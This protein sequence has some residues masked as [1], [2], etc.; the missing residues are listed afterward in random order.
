MTNEE[1]ATAIKN[2]DLDEIPFL[3]N[4]TFK[5]IYLL[6]KRFYTLNE[7][8]CHQYMVGLED[9]QQAGYFAFLTAID[10]FE[11]AR[12]YVFVSYL[13]YSTLNEF[14]AMIG[15]R[16][17]KGYKDPLATAVSLDKPLADADDMVV[18]DTVPDR[19]GE[20]AYESVLDDADRESKRN[21]LY[22]AIDHLASDLKP[23]VI[24]V[25]FKNRKLKDIAL[26]FNI[27]FTRAGTLKAKAL[28][29]L[30]IAKELQKYKEE[31]IITSAY[32]GTG[33]NSF[34]SLWASSV[35]QTVVGL[36]RRGLLW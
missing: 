16:T 23:I 30:R 10:S 34:K 9:L 19:S 27:D 17:K 31:Y 7:K 6:A 14:N 25:Y 13:R 21:D 8:R 15:H 18:G 1:L 3:W 24:D 12:G 4:Q 26:D 2:G 28:N 5:L 36:E 33:L 11:T 20:E 29:K 32:R 22:C 35:E